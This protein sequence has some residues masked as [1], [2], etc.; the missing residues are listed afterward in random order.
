MG[1]LIVGLVALMAWGDVRRRF[2][3]VAF[4]TSAGGSLVSRK[5]FCPLGCRVVNRSYRN[6]TLT[7]YER[8][9]T[10]YLLLFAVGEHCCLA[11]SPDLG[12]RP[13]LLRRGLCSLRA[14]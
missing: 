1:V 11:Y 10:A 13:A 4:V 3:K 5:R 8:N 9:N 14:P 2:A 12:L 6:L 7:W